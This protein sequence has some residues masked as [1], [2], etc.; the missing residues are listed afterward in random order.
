ME[1]AGYRLATIPAAPIMRASRAGKVAACFGVIRGIQRARTL[2]SASRMRLAIGS[3]S[4]ASGAALLAAR[5]L[6]LRTAVIEPNAI[7]GLANRLLRPV[8]D[9][10]YLTV[11]Q[12]ASAFSPARCLVTGTPVAPELARRLARR[13]ASPPAGRLV[14]VL[15]TG[16][17][18]G[19][20]FLAQHVPALLAALRRHGVDVEVMH[21]FGA[22]DPR[23]LD[24]RYAERNIAASLVAFIDD[25]GPAY[26]WA[27]IAV[28]RAGASTLAEIAL[29]GLPSLLVPLADAAADHQSA[30]A[31]AFAANG[32]ALWVREHEWDAAQLADQLASLLR[33]AAAWSAM[34]AAARAHATPD[35]AVRIV[36]DCETIMRSLW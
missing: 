4:Y 5:S 28:T 20:H 13:P 15:V 27:D 32:A 23:A 31:R 12:A 6:G 25:I 1:R 35:A 18:R 2:L 33:D 21:Q 30:N 10:V 17:S 11:P 16:A 24:D 19:E 7:A 26:E 3:G 9:R 14:R 34:S 36:D 29:A 8:T 22:S